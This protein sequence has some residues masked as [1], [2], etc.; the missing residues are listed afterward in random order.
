MVSKKVLCGILTAFL[1]TMV[2]VGIN[3]ATATSDLHKEKGILIT[4]E[5][6]KFIAKLQDGL[7]G[8]VFDEIK[9]VTL[10]KGSRPFWEVQ[11]SDKVTN[12]TWT[13]FVDAKNAESRKSVETCDIEG[14]KSWRSFDELKAT[15]VAQLY[16][17]TGELLFKRAE[18]KGS[19]IWMVPVVEEFNNEIYNYQVYFNAKTGYSYVADEEGNSSWVS[20]KGLDDKINS[21]NNYK[22]PFRNVLRDLYPDKKISIISIVLDHHLTLYPIHP[23]P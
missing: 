8:F 10:N 6:A 5:Q 13:V 11:V 3:P 21:E 1:V 9:K 15:Y 2:I 19:D 20:L 22:T 23:L 7:S 4:Q 17:D 12:E 14:A 18:M 16:Y